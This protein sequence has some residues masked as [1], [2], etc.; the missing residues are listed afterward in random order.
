[1]SRRRYLKPGEMFFGGDVL[2]ETLLGSCVAITLWFPQARCGGICH[3]M[4]PQR[5]REL[6]QHS[7]GLDGRYGREAWLWL[8]QQARAQLLDPALAEIK[9]F[10][11]ARVLVDTLSPGRDIGQQ[12][13]DLAESCLHEA[14]LQARA[15]DL[16]GEGHRVLRFDLNTGEVWLRRGAPMPAARHKE[17]EP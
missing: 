8:C 5:Q 15:R 16:G 9:L 3:Y 17:Y 14:G 2:V 1:M 12:N 6:R 11:G 7:R 13:I 4:L 10:G